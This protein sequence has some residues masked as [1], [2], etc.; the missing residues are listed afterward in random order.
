MTQF[1]FPQQAGSLRGHREGRGRCPFF[2]PPGAGGSAVGPRG[3]PAPGSTTS[4]TSRPVEP[5]RPSP[6]AGPEQSLRRSGAR[7]QGPIVFL[8]APPTMWALGSLEGRTS[9]GLQ[10]HSRKPPA[11]VA[12]DPSPSLSP[13]RVPETCCGSGKLS[14][15]PRLFRAQAAPDQVIGRRYDHGLPRGYAQDFQMLW[16]LFFKH[17]VRMS[18]T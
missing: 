6:G 8:T 12:A 18:R 5:A 3:A 1:V 17:V 11:R 15:A 4:V 2:P 10:R 16:F 9:T 13:F 7:K 14:S